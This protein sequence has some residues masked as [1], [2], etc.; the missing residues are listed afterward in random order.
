MVTPTYI[1]AAVACV[2]STCLELIAN[3]AP[4]SPFLPGAGPVGLAEDRSGVVRRRA[5][6]AYGRRG[7]SSATASISVY[8]DARS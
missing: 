4:T 8:Q 1:P 5:D 2:A 7:R 3:G 6:T